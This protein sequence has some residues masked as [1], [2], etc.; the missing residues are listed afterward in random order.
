MPWLALDVGGANIKIADG[1]GYA[2]SHPFALWK[3]PERLPHELRTAIAEGPACDHLA[4]TM[5]GELADCFATKQEGVCFILDAVEQA[6]DG[7]HTR[8]YLTNGTLV[9]PQV[10]RRRTVQAAAS[11]WCALATFAARFVDDAPALVVDV[12]ST[13]ADI[14]PLVDGRPVPAG[15]TDVDR[16]LNGELIYA[17]VERT[18]VCALVDT[19]PYRD[20][21]CPVARE[22]FATTRDVYTLTGDVPE[23]PADDNTA[24]G[25]PATKA[26]A[27]RRLG[28]MICVD[29]A[30]FHHRDA[31]TL[32]RAV[33]DR[34]IEL[35]N[36]GMD[37]VSQRLPAEPAVVVTAG[38]GEFITWHAL[39]QRSR[40]ARVVALSRELGPRISRC[41]PAHALAVLA[42]E[43]IEP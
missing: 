43:A 42:R 40:T 19:V 16:L 4:V 10:A 11:N 13:T 17:G 7:R 1:K 23:D 39:R 30:Q 22:L 21:A 3:H 15:L 25:R 38:Q 5:T 37:Q 34:Q 27:R 14:I 26:A 41:A 35:L 29:E 9:T 12:G 6:S 32:A 2:S 31:A 20:R 18:P 24:D 33:V 28:R 36:E 8:V